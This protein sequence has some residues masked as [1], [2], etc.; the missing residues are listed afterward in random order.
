M[1]DTPRYEHVVD[2]GMGQVG[3][4][5]EPDILWAVRYTSHGQRWA[6]YF[7]DQ[8]RAWLFHRSLAAK[9]E[10]TDLALEVSEATWRA[11]ET[12]LPSGRPVGGR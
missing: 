8:D 5:P 7:E 1:S 10:V 4:D 12:R 9:P 3:P 11:A 2:Q 6:N